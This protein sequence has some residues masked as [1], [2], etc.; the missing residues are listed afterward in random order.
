MARSD[1]TGKRKSREVFRTRVP[2]LGYYFIVT[3]AKETEENY[4][5]GLRDSLP[6]ELQ[7]RIVIKVSRAKTQELVETCKEQ[8]A[9]EPQYGQPWIVFDRDRVTNFDEIIAKAQ[10]ESVSVGW[11]NPCIEIWFDA[12]FGK[13]HSYSDSVVCC[14]KFAET[15]KQRTGQEYHKDNPQIYAVLNRFGDESKAIQIADNRLR[16]Y[17][18]DSVKKPSEM[19]PCT[20]IHKLISEIHCKTA[21]NVTGNAEK[22]N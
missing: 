8:A 2:D 21:Q 12:Y 17:L 10:K 22:N 15:F 9:L 19:C 1:R 4:L 5:Y 6:K 11:S 18:R 13:I 16:G 20:T 7:G 14:R 3:D